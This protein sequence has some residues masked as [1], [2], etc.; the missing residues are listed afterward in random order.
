MR[1]L[2]ALLALALLTLAGRA[3]D[4]RAAQARR[5]HR[6]QA[7]GL[8]DGR[9]KPRR[10]SPRSR[11]RA[12]SRRPTAR[13][14]QRRLQPAEVQAPEDRLQRQVLL[15]GQRHAERRHG[16][17]VVPVEIKGTFANG[18]AQGH[19]EPRPAQV[20]LRGVLLQRQELR[21]QPSGLTRLPAEQ[22]GAETP[23]G[24][25]A[26]HRQRR[27]VRRRR[28]P[29]HHAAGASGRDRPDE[30]VRRLDELDIVPSDVSLRRPSLDD[31]FLA[32]TG[33]G[34]RRDGR[35]GATGRRARGGA[36]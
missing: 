19:G 12:S 16:K 2:A 26:R 14:S 5:L 1:R 30:P 10:R 13:S 6:H 23:S 24:P 17:S 34:A 15:Q 7:P 8:R 3:G 20:G 27:A 4:R 22:A 11:R 21:R 25:A 35:E 28:R 31:V 32:L 9:R 33:H 36:A 29:A 18:Q